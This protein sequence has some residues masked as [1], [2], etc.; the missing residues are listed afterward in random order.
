MQSVEAYDLNESNFGSTLEFFTG[1]NNS[2][3]ACFMASQFS[4]SARQT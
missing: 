1:A 2:D 3:Q 4:I